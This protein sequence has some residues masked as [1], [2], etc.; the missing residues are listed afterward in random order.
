MTVAEDGIGNVLAESIAVAPIG[1]PWAKIFDT[2]LILK[3]N[4]RFDETLFVGEDLVFMHNYLLYRINIIRDGK[5]EKTYRR[6]G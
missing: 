4:I 6:F 2:G 1:I 5:R 3:N